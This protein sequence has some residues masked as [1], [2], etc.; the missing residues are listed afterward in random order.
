MFCIRKVKKM[1]I[2]RY[3]IIGELF[4]IIKNGHRKYKWHKL[5]PNSDTIPM[6][7]FNFEQVSVGDYSY[8]E[9]NVVDFGGK[10]K[11]IIG[12]YVSIAQH[13]TFLL[14]AEHYLNHISTYPFKVKMLNTEKEES[15]GKGN[16]VIDDDVWIGYGA[17]IMSG[18]HI[19]Q[20]AVIAAGA[21]VTN[22]VPP[23]AIV[24]GNPA[25]LIKYRFEKSIVDRLSN[26]NYL[27]I[28]SAFVINNIDHFY[29]GIETEE[30]LD[31]LKFREK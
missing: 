18:V 2:S 22:N 9:L 12:N 11:L 31:F 20:G 23:Y 10:C 4:E 19:G 25:K 24:G 5:H 28:D 3:S 21:I 6:N 1:M 27:S 15:F 26:V 7:N 8:G 16:I 30:D 17:T 29:K 13:V 14:N